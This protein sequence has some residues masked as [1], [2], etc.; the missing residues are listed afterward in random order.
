MI[1]YGGYSPKCLDY[2]NDIW[3]WSLSA[4]GNNKWSII[5]FQNNDTD[6]L[7]QHGAFLSHDEQYMYTVAGHRFDEYLI[8][9]MQFDLDDHSWRMMDHSNN[10]ILPPTRLAHAFSPHYTDSAV[11]P[12]GNEDNLAYIHG[13]YH[14]DYQQKEDTEYLRYLWSLEVDEDEEMVYWSN[15]SYHGLNETN[16]VDEILT[17]SNRWYAIPFPRMD[18]LILHIP[19]S[20]YIFL[21]GG[22]SS[23]DWYNDTWRYVML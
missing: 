4:S 10:S 22:Y 11:Y 16:P 17:E 20:S 6:R 21:F 23:G 13:G 2:C 3:K 19:N 7:W 14:S 12:R 18:H 8:D 9:I 5:K 1:V 15:I